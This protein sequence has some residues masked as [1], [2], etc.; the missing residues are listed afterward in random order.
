MTLKKLIK[1]RDKVRENKAPR[2]SRF[3]LVSLGRDNNFYFDNY[4]KSVMEKLDRNDWEY[5]RQREEKDWKINSTIIDH[6]NCRWYIKSELPKHLLERFVHNYTKG[7]QHGN[8][9]TYRLD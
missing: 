1:L 2:Y 3:F 4:T 7:L 5:W 8:F 9:R 6:D